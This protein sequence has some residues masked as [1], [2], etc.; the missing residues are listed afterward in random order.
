MRRCQATRA[1]RWWAGLCST[2]G[3]DDNWQRGTFARLFPRDAFSHVVTYTRETSALRGTAD[4]LLHAASY[5]SHLVLLSPATAAPAGEGPGPFGPAPPPTQ[6]VPKIESGRWLVI[7]P[8]R[9]ARPAAG[10]SRDFR[11]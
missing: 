4:M 1:L 9:A 7:V 3:H 8:G 6:T 5:G 10:R 11:I 2:G